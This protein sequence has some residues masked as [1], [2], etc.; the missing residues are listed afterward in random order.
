[1]LNI[2]E[3]IPAKHSNLPVKVLQ[4]GEGNFLRGFADWMIDTAN[5]QGILGS[6]I[7]LCQ[8]IAAGLGD[9][10][11]KQKGQ[12]TLIMRGLKDGRATRVV[13]PVSSVKCCLNPYQDFD[14][15]KQVAASAELKV[16]ISN[17]TEAGIAYNPD[18]RLDQTPPSSYPAKLCA[19]LHHRFTVLGGTAESGLVILP[20]ELIDRNGDNLKRIV[21]DYAAQWN[22]GDAFTRWICDHNCFA[23]TLVDRIVTGFPRDEYDQ[24]THELGY[25]DDLLT[26]SELFHFWVIEAPKEKSRVFPLHLA[27]LD[28]VWTD[29]MTPY[30]ERKVRILNGAHTMSVLAGYL[31]GHDTV[32]QLL[33][34]DLFSKFI[35]IG[36]FDEIIPTLDLPKE[37]L[38]VYANAVLERF[39]N[40]Y[41]KH[42]LIDITLN[43][44][45]KFKSRNLPSLLTYIQRKGCAPK[46]LTFSLATL[47]TFYYGK[48]EGEIYVGARGN[49][50]KDDQSVL[51]FFAQ[52]WSGFRADNC[53]ETLAGKI[54]S[55]QQ[56]W[57]QNLATDMLVPQLAEALKSIQEKGIKSALGERL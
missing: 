7:V 37:E 38:T 26:T 11:N 18:D 54:L 45:S 46:L 55:N 19:L 41:I 27:G 56:I 21:L 52:V 34:D 25:T 20:V 40:P 24:I 29:D 47:C 57:G 43:S 32:L 48:F 13:H 23:N 3:K 51:D 44:T 17:T 42:N 15:V 39:S 22:L 16:I 9:M 4:I 36:I 2:C 35:K 1:M 53:Y 31:A 8:P 33:Q 28:I 12:Y 14:A 49:Q 30:R 6:S 10:I 50:I 5:E